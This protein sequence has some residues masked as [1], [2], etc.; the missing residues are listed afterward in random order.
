MHT[1]AVCKRTGRMG[2]MWLVVAKGDKNP[3]KRVHRPCG[4]AVLKHIP[5]GISARVEPSEELRAE[6]KAKREEQQAQSFWDAKFAEAK[7]CKKP[8]KEVPEPVGA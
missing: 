7:A 5:E 3:P 8:S 1:C 2:A 4:E 6:W